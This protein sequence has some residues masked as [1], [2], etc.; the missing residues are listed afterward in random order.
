MLTG[1]ER[2]S[3]AASERNTCELADRAVTQA[4]GCGPFFS[5]TIAYVLG[6]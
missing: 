3:R 5:R 4:L 6:M 1:D 2:E